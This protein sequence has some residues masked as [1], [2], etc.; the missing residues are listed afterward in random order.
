MT[1]SEAIK[2]MRHY[3]LGEIAI[4]QFLRKGRAAP[5]SVIRR[6]SGL[7]SVLRVSVKD[8]RAA[9]KRLAAHVADNVRAYRAMKAR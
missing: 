4:L 8:K 6:G 2:A 7:S 1:R 5:D 3:L 9:A